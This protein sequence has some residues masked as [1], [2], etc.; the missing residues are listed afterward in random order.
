MRTLITALTP[1]Y[2]I[3]LCKWVLNTDFHDVGD[4]FVQVEP[5][6]E[7]AHVRCTSWIGGEYVDNFTP[8]LATYKNITIQCKPL[9]IT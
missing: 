8:D 7:H 2:D 5:L 3:I 6:T 1:A 4:T 9:Q